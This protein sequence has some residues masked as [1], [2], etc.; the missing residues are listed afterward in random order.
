MLSESLCF[1]FVCFSY[2]IKHVSKCRIETLQIC[3]NNFDEFAYKLLVKVC[4][5][6]SDTDCLWQ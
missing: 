6:T 3:R 1:L 2:T 5:A 4:I